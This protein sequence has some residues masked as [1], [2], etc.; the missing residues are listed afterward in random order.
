MA[1]A[2][3]MEKDGSASPISV[4]VPCYNHAPFVER[5]LRSIFAQTLAPRT[6]L[7]IDDGSTDGS[8]E[9]I[10]SVLKT[11]P[12]D[13]ELIVRE[14]RGLCATLNQAFS[15]S[16]GKYFAYLGADDFWFP[17]FL[18]RRFAMLEKRE[19]AV[20]GY[21]HAYFVDERDRI[22]HSTADMKET[23]SAFPDGN[24]RGLLLNAMAPISSTVFYR[25]SALKNVQWNENSRL[26]DYE[27]YIK[28]IDRGDFAF[29]PQ[30]L[31]VWRDHG[32]NTS[33]DQQMMLREVL[34]AQSRNVTALGLN[35]DELA[36]LQAKTKFRFARDLL[37]HGGKIEAARLARSSWRG[38]NS[39]LEL[40]RF[41]LRMAIP[42][43]VVRAVRRLKQA[44]R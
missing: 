12:F 17:E 10:A 43:F 41:I 24:A 32:Y 31:A 1:A 26:E 42:M 22:M 23:R 7:V 3:K 18:E 13:S 38:A 39:T 40:V 44:N 28:L 8:A 36:T 27:M 25:R 33:K 6:L 19:N 4:L 15:L 11:C 14:N 9:M 35:S 21:G 16:S 37:R 20:L 2:K 29:D 5:C 30:I 34:D